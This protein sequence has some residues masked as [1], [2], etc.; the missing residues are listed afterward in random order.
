MKV[1]LSLVPEQRRRLKN[2]AEDCRMTVDQYVQLLVERAVGETI[3][4]TVFYAHYDPATFDISALLIREVQALRPNQLV[5]AVRLF[6]SKTG[7]DLGMAKAAVE[8]LW[9][10]AGTTPSD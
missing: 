3:P 2:A 8:K 6:R 10:E 1:E 4:L 7:A 9:R 5:A